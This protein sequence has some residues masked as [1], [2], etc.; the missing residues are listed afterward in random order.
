MS[1]SPERSV[2][3]TDLVLPWLPEGRTVVL[4]DRGEVFV[5]WHR[6]A[7][8]DA[9]TVLLLH[10]WT[11]SADLQFFTAY[12]ALAEHYSF[13][14][15]DH[16]G[17]GRG[18]R[19]V[20]RFSLEDVADDAA[21]LL[22]TL[23]IPKVFTVGYSMGGPVSLLLARRNPD[24]VAGIVVEATALEWRAKLS[25]RAR[26]KTIR[27]V[28]PVLRSWSYPRWLRYGLRKLLGPSHELTVYVPWLEAENRRNDS[29]AIV[30]AGF[31]LSK[32]DARNWA[33]TLGKPAGSLITLRDRLVKPRKQRALA[34]ALD[35]HVVELDGDHLCTLDQPRAFSAGTL[36]LVDHL[37]GR[38]PAADTPI[39]LDEP[40]ERL[41]GQPA[42]D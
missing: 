16:R 30:Q 17:H 5:R 33:H 13:V 35:A 22:R 39:S 12:Q 34:E 8:P 14:A 15:I 20:A 24:L 25:E 1:A 23:G 3:P 4:P 29:H 42:V 2:A 28:G 37:T 7:D 27:I 36:A 32:F 9:P 10:G 40:T 21:A 26:W 11:A 38:V 19:T 6:H 41:V 31:S 18:M